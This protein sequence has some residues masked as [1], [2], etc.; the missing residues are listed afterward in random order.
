MTKAEN[1]PIKNT[2]R[3]LPPASF[4][5]FFAAQALS[6]AGAANWKKPSIDSPKRAIK[7]APPTI[8]AGRCSHTVSR[9][10][11]SPAATPT[12]V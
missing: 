1:T 3:K 4:P 12:A 11:V 7:T 9:L 2:E 10:P 8:T 5:D 6:E